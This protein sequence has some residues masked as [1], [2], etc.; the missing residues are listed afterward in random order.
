MITLEAV[1]VG[2][3][4]V[5]FGWTSWIPAL[6]STI[7]M[8]L[9]ESLNLGASVS[10]LFSLSVVIIFLV[11]VL[12]WGTFKVGRNG[13]LPSTEV[14]VFVPSRSLP[15]SFSHSTFFPT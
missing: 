9:A 7:W 12:G 14:V 6:L 3:K 4:K 5:T 1:F 11:I 13:Q 10:S 15:S 8:T 2:T